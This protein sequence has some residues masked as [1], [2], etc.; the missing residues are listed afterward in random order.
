[1]CCAMA[2]SCAGVFA[3]N[4][5]VQFGIGPAFSPDM[6][7]LSGY[8][9]WRFYK[10]GKMEFSAGPALHIGVRSGD[11]F[12]GP[13]ANLRYTYIHPIN[14]HALRISADFGLGGMFLTSG[15]TRSGFMISPGFGADYS[16]NERWSLAS[17]ITIHNGTGDAS[18][19]IV[20]WL[21]GV[22]YK[23]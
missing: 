7:Y 15:L 12:I 5:A 1:M 18:E 9:D 16:L 20:S 13:L 3:D 21:F 10:K 8:G 14:N 11:T 4:V 6:F 23:I 2:I 17:H 19:T 22:R